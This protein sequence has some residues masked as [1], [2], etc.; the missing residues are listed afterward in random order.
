MFDGTLVQHDVGEQRMAEEPVVSKKTYCKICTNQCGV[1]ID[2]AGDQIVRVKGDFAHPLSKGYTCPKGRAIGRAH[3]HPAAITRPQM[4]KDGQLVSVGWDD[5]LDDLAARLRAVIDEH[6]PNAVGFYFGSGL[7][8]DASGYRM[9]DTFYKALGAPPKFSPLTIDGTAKV[10][11]A[12]VVGGFPGLN[13]KT[14][15]DNVEMLLY[16]GV[17][18][19]V[20]HGHN[21]GMFN[22]A[23]PI[24][25]TAT[26]GEVW[27]IDPLLTETAKFST[28]TSSPIRART[29]RS[30]PGWYERSWTA[31]R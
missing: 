9:A 14:D 21:T 29:M 27:T 28:A 16:V 4:R 3:H 22:P 20:S 10:L 19:M 17:N 2:V 12:S 26:R 5:A 7:G 11:A 13:P 1:V 31:A 8:M 30:S 23:G 15:Y 25:A 24:R 18:P 6:G